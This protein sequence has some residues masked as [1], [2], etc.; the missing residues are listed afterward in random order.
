[1]STKYKIQLQINGTTYDVSPIWREGTKLQYTQEQD[2]TF[3]DL[4]G[5]IQE[6]FI[7]KRADFDL[8]D[9]QDFT[10][11]FTL[12]VLESIDNGMNYTPL[13]FI[14]E[15]YK[16]N[17]E[18]DLDN[19][20]ISVKIQT[21]D[22]YRRVYPGLEKEQDLIQLGPEVN[23]LLY[24]RQAVLQIH[25]LNTNILMNYQA[26]TYWEQIFD[27]DAYPPTPGDVNSGY[28]SFPLTN[29]YKFGQPYSRYFIPGS[30]SLSPDVSGIYIPATTTAGNIW[31]EDG[32][33]YINFIDLG[34]G[35]IQNVL[36]DAG[37]TPVFAMAVNGPLTQTTLEGFNTYNNTPG[38][39]FINVSDSSIRCQVFYWAFY[40]RVLTN[41]QTLNGGQPTFELPDPDITVEGFGFTRVWPLNNPD[42]YILLTDLNQPT[43]SRYGQFVDDALH[44]PNQYFQLPPPSQGFQRY[45]INRSTWKYCSAWFS[46]GPVLYSILQEGGANVTLRHAYTLADCLNLLLQELDPAV[47]FEATSDYSAFLYPDDGI[48]PVS[49]DPQPTI[50]CSPKS[51]FTLG[52]Y[53]RPAQKAITKLSQFLQMLW[54][55]YRLKWYIDD[56]GRFRLEHISYFEKGLSYGANNVGSDLTTAIEPKTGLTWAYRTSKYR[57]N[58]QNLAEEIRT[59]YMDEQSVP[60][61]GFP[62][63]IND[64]FV[65]PGNYVEEV[66]RFSA[67]LDFMTVNSPLINREGFA[68]FAAVPTG[69]PKQWETEFTE[70]EAPPG[71]EWNIQNGK[72]AFIYLHPRYHVYGLPAPDVKIN[73]EDATATTVER[74]KIQEL[75][76]PFPNSPDTLALIATELG[77]GQLVSIEIPLGS[78]LGTITVKHDTQ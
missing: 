42:T 46:Y 76:Y 60:F 35:G 18:F 49:G 24:N 20:E 67:D 57:Y 65:E 27:R 62:I 68:L 71:F 53:D 58:K 39:D 29:Y 45:P 11:K 50:L 26:G 33:Y 78:R 7:F 15:F 2:L 75:T 38:D 66:L 48:N 23:E 22:K 3:A 61:E 17:C 21:D 8:I 13:P 56:A 52:E 63:P 14:G 70:I 30:G 5:Q 19:K 51:N 32:A 72:L 4:R 1:M 10:T 36:Y 77:V 31:R 12:L 44:F 40:A 43:N 73:D 54:T 59:K 28:S 64:F 9:S 34:A 69:I 16:T 41:E 74:N 37:G 6:T 55:V 25:S 47:T